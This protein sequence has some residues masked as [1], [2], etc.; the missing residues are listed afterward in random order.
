MLGRAL[1]AQAMR[2]PRPGFTSTE[3]H[4]RISANASTIPG[5]D[6]PLEMD[7]EHLPE[8]T[9]GSVRAEAATCSSRCQSRA[10]PRRQD[11]S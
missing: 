11:W 5:A 1:V 10:E 9:I 4:Y 3:A 7:E 8:P 2:D 6:D